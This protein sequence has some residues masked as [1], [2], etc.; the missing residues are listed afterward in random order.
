MAK[1][2]PSPSEL[3]YC[4][5]DLYDYA[6]LVNLDINKF[7]PTILTKEEIEMFGALNRASRNGD[8]YESITQETLLKAIRPEV[9]KANWESH[10]K[11][12]CPYASPL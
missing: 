2:K 5:D 8:T 1:R 11:P 3:G 12:I 4:L 9:Y 6:R 7:L 10:I